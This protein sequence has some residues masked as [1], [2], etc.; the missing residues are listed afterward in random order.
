MRRWTIIGAALSAL[1]VGPARAE[2]CQGGPGDQHLVR[3]GH[4]PAPLFFAMAWNGP[5]KLERAVAIRC[6]C[7]DGR[8]GRRKDRRGR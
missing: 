6:L 1:A 4:G 7:A 8:A 5:P 3:I 2:I